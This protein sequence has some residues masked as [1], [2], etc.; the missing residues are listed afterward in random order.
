[1]KKHGREPIYLLFRGILFVN[2]YSHSVLAFVIIYNILQCKFREVMWEVQ[3][4][5]DINVDG[6]SRDIHVCKIHSNSS[7]FG[8]NMIYNISKIDILIW[9][10]M[11]HTVA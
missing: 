2:L 7:L 8:K 1:M 3:D 10:E 11:S 6:C 9:P 5:Q 4:I